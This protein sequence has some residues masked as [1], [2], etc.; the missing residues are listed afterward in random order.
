MLLTAGFPIK[1]VHSPRHPQRHGGQRGF[2]VDRSRSSLMADPSKLP[3]TPSELVIGLGASL[4]LGPFVAAKMQAPWRIFLVSIN[5]HLI[6]VGFD[7][8]LFPLLSRW[9]RSR[10]LDQPAREPGWGVPAGPRAWAS[11]WVF[12]R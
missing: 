11:S 12:D 4:E 7:F 9:R 6:S 10:L 5:L 2:A 1:R 3:S 8:S